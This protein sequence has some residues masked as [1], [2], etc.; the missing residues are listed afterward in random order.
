MAVSPHTIP[1]R[2]S[3][4]SLPLQ[5]YV[6]LSPF[7]DGSASYALKAMRTK[8]NAETRKHQKSRENRRCRSCCR[9]R[10][11]LSVVRGRAIG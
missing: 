10:V 1:N 7:N 9:H 3:S 2:S 11:R 6:S 8:T 4:V 5:I